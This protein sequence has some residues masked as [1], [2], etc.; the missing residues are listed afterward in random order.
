MLTKEAFN[1]LLKTLEEPPEHVVFILATTET[2][3]L[4]ETIISRTQRFAFKP[5]GLPKVVAHLRDIA[6]KEKIDI[7]D[8]ALELIAQHGE[9]SFRDSISLLDQIRNTGDKVTLEDVQRTLGVAP[10]EFIEALQTALAGHDS[11]ALVRTLQDI[12]G[13]GLDPSQIARQLGRA[14][15]QDLMTGKNKQPRALFSLLAQLVDVPAS[16]DPQTSLEIALLDYALGDDSDGAASVAQ[17]AS[18]SPKLM[19]EVVQAKPIAIAEPHPSAFRRADHTSASKTNDAQAPAGVKTDK[20]EP[21]NVAKASDSEA[22]RKEEA[23]PSA[24][25]LSKAETNLQ[26]DYQTAVE[27]DTA[28]ELRMGTPLDAAAWGAILTAVKAK[29]NTLYS[30][31]RTARPHFEDPGALTLE[32][33]FAFHQ[34]RLNEKRNKEVLA[35][36]IEQ[37]TGQNVIINCVVGEAATPDELAGP[38]PLPPADEQI[39]TVSTPAS[40]PASPVTI[41]APTPQQ[42]KT[43]AADTPDTTIETISNIFG[44]AELL[45]S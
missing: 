12:H 25:R 21:E 34:K 13:Q 22:T 24:A 29:H 26:K 8:D 40:A 35:E 5:V 27:S 7:T 6:T 3:K 16:R 10:Q 18:A 42:P 30:I 11:L 23:A 33:G 2:H 14:M 43:T 38:P 32:C 45:E 37:T 36:V 28:S 1:A 9:G 15:R 19:R 44:G 31:V 41:A 20:L 39:H 4:P 17:P